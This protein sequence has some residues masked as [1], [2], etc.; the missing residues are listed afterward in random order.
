MHD[1]QG[2]RLRAEDS[3]RLRLLEGKDVRVA[4]REVWVEGNCGLLALKEAVQN[5]FQL[6][7]REAARLVVKATFDVER[8][9]ISRRI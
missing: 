6:E 4:I 9:T 3:L 7:S 5:V 1:W 2:Q 8:G